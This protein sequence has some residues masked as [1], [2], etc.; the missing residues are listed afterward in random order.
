M[1]ISYSFN[2]SINRSG[3]GVGDAS[4]LVVAV[5]TL[6]ILAADY[7][8]GLNVSDL[9]TVANTFGMGVNDVRE[10]LVASVT[11]AAGTTMR[12]FLGVWNDA[13][14]KLHLYKGATPLVQITSA[15]LTDGDLVTC[16]VIFVKAS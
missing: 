14:T 8:T 15:D 7:S 11:D 16:F 2:G 12:P 4:S 10:I 6:T 3:S 9:V 13:A 5:V 1:P